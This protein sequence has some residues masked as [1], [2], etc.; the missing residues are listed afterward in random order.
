M[1][2]T[3]YVWDRFVRFFH[4][5][6][7]LLFITSY[8]SGEEEHWIHIYSGYA[9]IAL[10]TA[11]ILWGFIGSRYARFSEF[12]Y[13][14]WK[15]IGYL[16]GLVTGQKPPRYLG[17]NPAGGLMVLVMLVTLLT[18]AFS[19]LKLYALEEGKGPFANLNEVSFVEK[20]YA[21]SNDDYDRDHDD[22]TESGNDEE[23][24]EEAEEYWEEIH[25]ASVNF[26]I[27][28]II[29]HVGGVL[30]SSRAHGES[31][32]RAMITGRKDYRGQSKN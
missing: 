32:V 22:D 21:D 19:G 15:A 30:L 11:R 18:I 23:G 8:L 14:P 20:V 9:I 12:I 1:S 7:V 25:E 4:W 6:L 16:R 10:V 29:L 2:E 28:L 27:I 31:L 24:H 17:H 5:S 3:V 13:S 26:M